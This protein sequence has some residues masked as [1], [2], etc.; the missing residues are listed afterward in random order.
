[1]VRAWTTLPCA[2]LLAAAIAPA[3]LGATPIP[4]GSP[5]ASAEATSFF[6]ALVWRYRQLIRYADT[7][8]L[9]QVVGATEALPAE[10]LRTSVAVRTVIEE[11]RIEVS[12]A[13]G[14]IADVVGA[15]PKGLQRLGLGRTPAEASLRREIDLTLSPH[16]GL[17]VLDEPLRDFRPGR[18]EG[19]TATQLE[20]IT[21]DE[22]EMIRL[23]LRSGGATHGEPAA[24]FGLTV[25]PE[26]MLI[27]RIEGSERLPDGRACTT[28]LSIEPEYAE[29]DPAAPSPPPAERPATLV[30]AA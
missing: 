27:R 7:S 20:R 15:G 10:D 13:S 11:G 24:V 23:E 22:R 9:E 28:D 12:T 1:M 18:S 21:V 25:D 3:A 5:E 30:P 19:F 16:L 26:S 4:P 6:E 29:I 2:A 14:R 8:R 17:R